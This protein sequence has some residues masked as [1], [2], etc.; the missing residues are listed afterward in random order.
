VLELGVQLIL[1]EAS[2]GRRPPYGLVVLAEGVQ[3]RIAFDRSL[4]DA[5]FSAVRQMRTSIEG[6]SA[7]GRRW[8]GARCR[9]CEFYGTCWTS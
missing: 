5:V 6:D 2:V 7:P 1:V 4:E 8:L 9:A 3:Q